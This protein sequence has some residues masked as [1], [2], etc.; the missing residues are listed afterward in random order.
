MRTKSRINKTKPN[1]PAYNTKQ[2]P[3][4]ISTFF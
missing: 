4:N 1:T 3:A 2:E